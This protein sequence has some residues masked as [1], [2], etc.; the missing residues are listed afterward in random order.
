MALL[1]ATIVLGGAT[2]FSQNTTTIQKLPANLPA[3]GV[4]VISTPDYYTNNQQT[5]ISIQTARVQEAGPLVKGAMALQS[6]SRTEIRPPSGFVQ[7]DPWVQ[8]DHPW[9]IETNLPSIDYP[10]NP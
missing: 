9:D 4:K 6:G 5:V 8:Q 7:P 1:A 3:T 10:P 2:A